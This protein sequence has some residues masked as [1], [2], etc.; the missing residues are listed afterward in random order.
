MI[1]YQSIMDGSV[2][3]KTHQN[4]IT[5]AAKMEP[6]IYNHVP[7]RLTALPPYRSI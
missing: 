2:I 7:W 1:C 5:W 3:T 4:R 6:N